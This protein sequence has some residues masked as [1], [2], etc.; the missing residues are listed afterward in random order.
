MGMMQIS[1]RGE[2]FRLEDE[3]M[4]GKW[5][6]IRIKTREVLDDPLLNPWDRSLQGLK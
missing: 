5:L 1:V 4:K 3:L 2:F 6:C